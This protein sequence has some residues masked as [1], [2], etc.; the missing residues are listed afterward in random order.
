MSDDA[1]RHGQR[2]QS[3][4]VLLHGVAGGM[5]LLAGLA[6]GALPGVAVH[7]L[8]CRTPLLGAGAILILLGGLRADRRGARIS[9]DFCLVSA[10]AV[11]TLAVVESGFRAAGFDFRRQAARLQQMPPFYRKPTLPTGTV[12]FRREGPLEWNGPVIR[13]ML[14]CVGLDSAAYAD[15]PAITVRYDQLGFRN[16]PRPAA[17]E[18]AVAGDSFTELGHLS[19]EELFTT[20]LGAALG[21]RVLNLG[22]GNT[23][24][25]TQL[26]YLRDYG[27]SPATRQVLI[28][29]FEG[30]DLDDLAYERAAERRFEAT[31]R[32]EFRT[33]RKQTSFLR[34]VGERVRSGASP[35]PPGNPPVEAYLTLHNRRIP[36][37]VGPA[38]GGRA[39]LPPATLEALERFVEQFSALAREHGVRA[40][41]AYMPC[42]RRVWHGH[43][44]FADAVAESIRFWEPSDL[45]A[46]LRERCATHA[47]GFL[48]LTPPLVAGTLGAGEPVYNLLYDS[49]LNA[50]G[51]RV[52]AETLRVALLRN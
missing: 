3:L 9:R 2:S 31:G 51:S 37:T 35:P 15:E 27:L 38:P 7:W 26:S 20:R 47:I 34:A 50:R 33:V 23:G 8:P 48:D 40:W 16:E 12:F 17:W 42:K 43:L 10:A 5:L 46:V 13:R 32:R 22:A 41:L 28:V 52:V 29:F 14:D 21:V 19:F 1:T 25:L 24:P 45:P 4:H 39:E 11:L 18:L 30:N 6:V 36:V 44:E 49:H